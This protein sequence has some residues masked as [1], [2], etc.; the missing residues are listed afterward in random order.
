MKLRKILKKISMVDFIIIFTVITAL[1]IG[2]MTFTKVRQTSDKQIVSTSPIEFHVLVRGF[3]FTGGELPIKQ[4]GKTFITIRNV[5][6][7]EL[8]VKN[9]LAQP[10]MTMI[11][12]NGNYKVVEDPAFPNLYDMVVI[13]SD[14]AKVTKDGP[15]VGGNKLKIGLPIT[16]EGA[17]YKLNGTVSNVIISSEK[18]EISSKAE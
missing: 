7:T 16:I 8:E 14:E 13:V 6:Y 2:Y 17:E 9:V 4:G 5:P 18:Q 15:V 12:T 10:R 11:G 1:I 3:S